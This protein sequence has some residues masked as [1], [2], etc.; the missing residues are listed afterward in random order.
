MPPGCIATA[1]TSTF[2]RTQ[3]ELWFTFLPLAFQLGPRK[4]QADSGVE[5]DPN[6]SGRPSIVLEAG[7]SES[8]TQLKID[9]RLW[10]EH[11]PEVSQFLPLLPL[12]YQNFLSYS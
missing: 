12:T 10:L 3:F 6:P 7:S 4:K 5:P 11:V 8:L 9:M 2:D 1:S